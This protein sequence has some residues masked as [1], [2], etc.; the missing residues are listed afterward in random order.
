MPNPVPVAESLTRETRTKPIRRNDR[1][2]MDRSDPSNQMATPIVRNT[3]PTY[4]C[5]VPFDFCP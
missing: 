2:Q 5:R 3:S 4:T 1:H